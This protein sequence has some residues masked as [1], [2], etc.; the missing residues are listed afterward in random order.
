MTRQRSVI[1]EE[2]R[3]VDTH[4][5]ADDLY[6]IV[7]MRLPHISLGTVYRNLEYLVASGEIARLESAGSSMRFDG[8]VSGHQHVRCV[9]CGRVADLVYPPAVP[10]LHGIRVEG[11]DKIVGVR[12]E[13]DGVCERCAPRADAASPPE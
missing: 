9:H 5:T 13:F 8:D 1:L 6:N 4:P 11:F 7:R 2:L 12:V 10:A 3:K